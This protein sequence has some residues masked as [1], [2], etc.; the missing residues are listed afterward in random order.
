MDLVDMCLELDLYLGRVMD[1]VEATVQDQGL[2][3][4]QVVMDQEALELVLEVQA[5]VQ[6]D[7]KLQS[8]GYLV[9]LHLGQEQGLALLELVQ[10]PVL[11]ELVQGPALLELVQGPALLELVHGLALLELVQGP[12]LVFQ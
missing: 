9:Q 1:Q 4:D 2:D 7:L 8:T 10:G 12:A 5:T 3:M 6:L 11:L